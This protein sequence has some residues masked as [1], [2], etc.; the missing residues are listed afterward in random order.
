VFFP[1]FLSHHQKFPEEVLAEE[2]KTFADPADEGLVGVNFGY[3]PIPAI[4]DAKNYAN[5][6][7][8]Y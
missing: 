7:A 4:S 3:W 6:I 1:G 8:A 2:I 5:F